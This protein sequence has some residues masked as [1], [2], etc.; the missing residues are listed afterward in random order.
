MKPVTSNMTI[1]NNANIM[2]LYP[3]LYPMDTSINTFSGRIT[4][5]LGTRN[6]AV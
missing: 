2:A 5:L 3:T 1:M 4:A 6:L